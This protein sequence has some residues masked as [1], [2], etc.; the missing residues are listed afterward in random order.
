[1]LAEHAILI[2]IILLLLAVAAAVAAMAA[3]LVQVV[4]ARIHLQ[5]FRLQQII[6]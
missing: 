4:I 3:E 1:V 2:L 6:L 5:I